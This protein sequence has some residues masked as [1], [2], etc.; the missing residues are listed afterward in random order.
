MRASATMLEHCAQRKHSPL[1]F[2]LKPA[3]QS[4]VVQL[5]LDEFPAVTHLACAGLPLQGAHTV[6]WIL[7][8]GHA[9]YHS[10]VDLMSQVCMMLYV[11]VCVWG[12]G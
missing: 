9:V 3:S 6:S 10:F 5:V 12:G 1:L 4:Q 11:C 7:L 8:H 2:S